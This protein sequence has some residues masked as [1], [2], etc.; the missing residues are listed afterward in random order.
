MNTL[1]YETNWRCVVCG[2]AGMVTVPTSDACD[3]IYTAVI[4]QHA[5]KSP[6]CHPHAGLALQPAAEAGMVRRP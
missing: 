4:E 6:D 5:E 1:T 3:S 2:A